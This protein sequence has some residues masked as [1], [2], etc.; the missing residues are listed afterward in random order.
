M[1]RSPKALIEPG[2]LVWARKSAAV[3]IEEAAKY[4]GT[5][6]EKVTAW[7]AGKDRPTI[8]QLYKIAAKYKRP[9]SVF[10]LPKPPKDFQALKDFRR[11]PGEIAHTSTPELAYGI[12]AAQERRMLA[13][14]LYEDLREAPPVFTL[15]ASQRQQPDSLAEEI[16]SFL[17]ITDAHQSNWRESRKAY[18]AWRDA[19]EA[20][21]AL[22]FQVSG[23]E[24]QEM[25]GF[26]IAE[27]VLPVIGVNSRDTYTG[28]SFS[29]IHELVHLALRQ[30]G[31]SDFSGFADDDDGRPPE[32]QR[33]EVFCN[34]VAASTLMPERAF[35]SHPAVAANRGNAR[36]TN[37]DLSAVARAFGVSA[38]ATLRRLLT[39]GRTTVGFY[40]EK[41]QEFLARYER[42]AQEQKERGGG[43]DRPTTVL[44]SF[45]PS[46]TKLLLQTYYEKRI[47]LSELSGYL[48]LKVPYIPR[49]ENAVYGRGG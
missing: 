3:S 15:T 48:N 39:F 22:A 13:L 18:N 9:V 45:G 38:E 33:I 2:V 30:S 8:N 6:V 35:L 32:A 29:L 25:R 16:R 34:Q 10:Y 27:D 40:R 4:F 24:I 49:L 28:R 36:W 12:R 26:A 5:T 43:P 19:I 44:A 20:R 37:E 11:L 31:V 14:G 41:R 46:F 21:S 17:G 42:Q 1:A 23:I 7:E 47:T